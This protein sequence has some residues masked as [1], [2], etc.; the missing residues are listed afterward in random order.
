MVKMTGN[1]VETMGNP[2]W[3]GLLLDLNLVPVND[4]MALLR[5][6][7]HAESEGMLS[8]AEYINKLLTNKMLQ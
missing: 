7:N 1:Q 4:T 8:M 3:L 2:P 6:I 5:N